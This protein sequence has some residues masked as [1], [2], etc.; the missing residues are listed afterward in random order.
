MRI[1]ERDIEPN[2]TVLTFKIASKEFVSLLSSYVEAGRAV[3]LA[4][5]TF[6][7]EKRLVFESLT[8]C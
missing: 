6:L 8:G 2:I 4:T 3:E 7:D 5:G 1:I